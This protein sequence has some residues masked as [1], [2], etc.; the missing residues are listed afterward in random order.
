MKNDKAQINLVVV[1][2]SLMI[3]VYSIAP[4]HVTI[5]VHTHVYHTM[6]VHAKRACQVTLHDTGT[7]CVVLFIL[8][9]MQIH[10]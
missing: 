5:H 4:G 7:S 1:G 2:M 10:L 6:Y 9:N 3:V 8:L